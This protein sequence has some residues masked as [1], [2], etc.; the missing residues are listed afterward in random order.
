MS[1]QTAGGGSGKVGKGGNRWEV[2][3]VKKGR[4]RSEKP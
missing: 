4:K 1:R 2:E 3:R